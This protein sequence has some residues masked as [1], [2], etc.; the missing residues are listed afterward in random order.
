LSKAGFFKSFYEI[1]VH[2][3]RCLPVPHNLWEETG[4]PLEPDTHW[5][6]PPPLQVVGIS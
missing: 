3:W 6:K 5:I 2:G 4:H 1:R